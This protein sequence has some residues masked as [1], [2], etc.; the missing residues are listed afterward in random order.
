MT[1]EKILITGANGFIGS[2]LTDFCIKK[3]YIVYAF[4]IPNYPL[5][6]LSHYTNGKISYSKSDK[7]EFLGEPIRIPTTNIKRSNQ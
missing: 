5:R 1:M 2:H 6:N 7:I 4:D 3:G